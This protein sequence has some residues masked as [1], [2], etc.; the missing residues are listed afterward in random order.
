ML[1]RSATREAARMVKGKI[2]LNI[3]KS[4]DIINAF[5]ELIVHRDWGRGVGILEHRTLVRFIKCTYS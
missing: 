1:S 3:K 5:V 2:C 4:Q